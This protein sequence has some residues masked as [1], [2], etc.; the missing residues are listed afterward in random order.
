MFW[1]GKKKKKANEFVDELRRI[2]DR[3][4]QYDPESE[5]YQKLLARAES[6]ANLIDM[7]HRDGSISRLEW[8]KILSQVGITGVVVAADLT[9]HIVGKSSLYRF[10]P[11]FIRG[12]D[13]RRRE[14]FKN[15]R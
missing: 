6:L 15:K 13:L 11:N 9:G 1:F 2:K 7:E 14:V 12:G 5:E 10:I 3:M 4:E 8:A